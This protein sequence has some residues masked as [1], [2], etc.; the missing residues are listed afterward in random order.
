MIEL[1]QRHKLPDDSNVGVRFARMLDCKAEEERGQNGRMMISAVA[2]TNGIDLENEVVVP[3][4]ADPSYFLNAKAIYWAHNSFDLPVATLRSL[5][6]LPDKSGWRM[7][8]ST[9][10]TE[11]ARDVA[12]CIAEGAING[13]SIGFLRT[14]S[15]APSPEEIMRYG[16]CEYVT[17]RWRWLETSITPMPCN[18]QALIDGVAV[19][20]SIADE[21]ASAISRLAA[22]GRISR[23]SAESMGVKR[24]AI[25]VKPV[26]RI[27]VY[28]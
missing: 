20:K 1:I 23:K 7:Q 2:T 18:P 5:R 25:V 22:K 21:A 15:G 6:L 14:D 3:E 27:P 16:P 13:V 9:V 28:S 12:T 8:C 26:Y 17:R 24:K 10:N 4:G 11:F 19:E